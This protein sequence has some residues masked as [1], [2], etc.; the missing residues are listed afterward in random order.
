MVTG[1]WAHEANRCAKFGGN[2]STGVFSGNRSGIILM[3]AHSGQQNLQ[4][5][6]HFPLQEHT[7]LYR[8]SLS[9]TETQFGF[10][11]VRI[12]TIRQHSG[13]SVFVDEIVSFCTGKCVSVE[14]MPSV[15]KVRFVL[16][17]SVATVCHHTFFIYT[18]NHKKSPFYF[19][20][21]L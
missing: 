21:N 1:D 13:V 10:T 2:L 16:Q 14:E 11:R 19:S 5:E 3:V 6:T 12:D 7:F 18:V 8:N 20:N 17:I 15:G 9:S 4:Y